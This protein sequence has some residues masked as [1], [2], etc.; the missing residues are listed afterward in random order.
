VASLFHRGPLAELELL[1]GYRFRRRGLLER[2]LTHSSYANERGLD[3][4]YERLEFLG[5]AVLGAVTAE[6]LFAR[7]PELA[8]GDLS[9]RKSRLVSERSLAAWAR[10]IGLGEHLRLGLGEDRSGGR[11]KR[12]LLADAMEA[13]IGA[14]FLDG[15][16]RAARHIAERMLEEHTVERDDLDLRDPKTRLQEWAQAR[17]GELPVYRLHSESGPDHAKTFVVEC[18]VDGVGEGMGEG[19]SKKAAEQMAALVLLDAV[20]RG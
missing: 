13:V 11:G 2:A 14:A 3:E 10:Q 15:G 1:I 18:R 19:R 7:Y 17:G 6:W 9:S 8:E 16:L 20:D 12:S 4:H 5:D